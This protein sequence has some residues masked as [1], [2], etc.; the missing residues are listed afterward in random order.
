M[1][2]YARGVL[3]VSASTME[4]YREGASDLFPKKKKKKKK[5]KSELFAYAVE[6]KDDYIRIPCKAEMVSK[7]SRQ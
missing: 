1:L 7:H 5:V 6:T 3:E 2:I 4:L